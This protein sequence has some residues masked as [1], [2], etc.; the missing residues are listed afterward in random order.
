MT[1]KHLP[2]Y[3]DVTKTQ[4][5]NNRLIFSLSI[6]GIHSCKNKHITR[7]NENVIMTTNATSKNQNNSNPFIPVALTESIH[8]WKSKRVFTKND[9][10]KYDGIPIHIYAI[11]RRHLQQNRN[12]VTKNN[13][14]K[15]KKDEIS[16]AIDKN[17]KK[18]DLK[19]SNSNI[20]VHILCSSILL[21]SSTLN[22]AK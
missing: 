16:N 19:I 21:N 1:V 14:N 8:S 13:L 18:K 11:G 10:N 4:N 6:V 5:N 22:S 15:S 3:Y 20:K 17:T 7:N 9:N 2:S 12:I